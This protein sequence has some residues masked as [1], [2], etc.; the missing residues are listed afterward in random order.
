M[1]QVFYTVHAS[2]LT[3]SQQVRARVVVAVGSVGLKAHL[4]VHA[5][6]LR[7]KLQG[8]QATRLDKAQRWEQQDLCL[9]ARTEQRR[10][11]EGGDRQRDTNSVSSVL[12]G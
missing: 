1:T 12:I 8:G 5:Q 6:L 9:T 7:D 11:K 10:V 3:R 4:G 2:A